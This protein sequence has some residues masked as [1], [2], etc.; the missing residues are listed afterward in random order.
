MLSLPTGVLSLPLSAPFFIFCALFFRVAPQLTVRLEEAICMVVPISS[1]SK[2][3]IDKQSGS[4]L[5]NNGV[6]FL[7]FSFSNVDNMHS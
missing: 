7:G 3:C 4:C 2:N 5:E 6:R 1:R